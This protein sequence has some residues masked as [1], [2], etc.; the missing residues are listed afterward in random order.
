MVLVLAALNGLGMAIFWPSFQ[1]WVA[2]SQT[3]S[4]LARNIGSFNMSWTA[5]N[6]LGPTLSGI[7]FS[8]YPR[9]PFLVAGILSFMLF[10]LLRASVRRPGPQPERRDQRILWKPKIRTGEVFPLC[11]L[12]R[13]LRFLVHPGKPAVSVSQAGPG[14]GHEPFHHRPAA[15]LRRLFSIP[16]V[17]LASGSDRWHFKK[18]FLLGAQLLGAAG[19]LLILSSAISSIRL[20][21]YFDRAMRQ[22]DL[23]L[24]P[25]L[26]SASPREKGKRNGLARI[27]SGKRRGPRAP[28]G[29]GRCPNRRVENP[30]SALPGSFA[31]SGRGGIRSPS[32]ERGD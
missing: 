26:C 5:A 13:Q 12:D 21:L 8:L 30:L 18:C 7:L 1:A 14:Y 20:R 22:P 6:L 9:V 25:V 15:E 11:Y 27:H 24:K 17:L 28:A 23:L 3:G 19:L 31:G 10:F 4:N 32:K 2:D 16:R 29:R